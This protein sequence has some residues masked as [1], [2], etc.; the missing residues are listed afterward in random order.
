LGG[1]LFGEGKQGMTFV[2][3]LKIKTIS[4]GKSGFSGTDSYEGDIHQ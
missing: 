4:K 1:V 2:L 3:F